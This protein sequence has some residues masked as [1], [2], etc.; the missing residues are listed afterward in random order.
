MKSIG[1]YCRQGASCPATAK[2]PRHAREQFLTNKA[3]R[4][5]RAFQRSAGPRF[6]LGDAQPRAVFATE[7]TVRHGAGRSPASYARLCLLRDITAIDH[8]FGT[9]DERCLVGCQK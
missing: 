8:Q 9:G 6:R 2:S 5:P 4:P 3:A 1:R 7:C